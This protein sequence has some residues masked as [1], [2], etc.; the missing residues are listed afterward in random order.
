MIAWLL[1]AASSPAA[2]AEF[3]SSPVLAACQARSEAH[4][5][6]RENHPDGRPRVEA[7]YLNGER[8]GPYVEWY[9]DG[10]KREEGGYARDLP[11]GRWSSWFPNGARK[12]EGAYSNGHRHGRWT[13]WQE[14]SVKLGEGEYVCDESSG[15]WEVWD[16]KRRAS[17]RRI[18]AVEPRRADCTEVRVPSVP[19]IVSLGYSSIEYRETG[20]RDYSMTALTAKAAY[21]RALGARGWG[22][23]ASGYLTALPLG[24]NR[25]DSTMRFLG[26][27]LRFG[28][29]VPGVRAPWKLSLNTGLYYTTTLV[30]NNAF[31]F[32]NMFGPQ[33]YP[34][35][36]R[37]VGRKDVVGAYLKFSPMMDGLSFFGLANRELAAGLSWTRPLPRERF[38]SASVDYAAFRLDYSRINIQSNSFSLS[39]GYG[40]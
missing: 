28:Y 31:G 8:D 27:N 9:P 29:T 36:Q 10:R 33:L 23:S 30:T 16:P 22:A 3:E 18:F 15:P 37:L 35:L 19:V 38:L 13:T 2:A 32:T 34:T 7:C 14:D 11:S 4:L 26:L 12:S 21:Q 40:W 20:H 24:R 17:A 1:F 25:A 39:L 5:Y 6:E